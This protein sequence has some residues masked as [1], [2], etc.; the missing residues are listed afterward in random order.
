MQ[1]RGVDLSWSD[2]I[3]RLVDA[4]T[5]LWVRRTGDRLLASQAWLRSPIGPPSGE[6]GNWRQDYP[7]NRPPQNSAG[8]IS[9]FEAL[10]SPTFAVDAVD[11]A[12]QNFYTSTS[13]WTMRLNAEWSWWAIAP[14]WALRRIFSDRL[15]QL[16]IPITAHEDPI[17]S[18]VS[19]SDDPDSAQPV[20]IWTRRAAKQRVMFSGLYRTR[21]CDAENS[22]ALQVTFPLPEGNLNVF[23][24]PTALSGGG[25]LLESGRQICQYPA[26][27]FTVKQ[28]SDYY[29]RS[30][31]IDESFRLEAESDR[32]VRCTHTLRIWSIRVFTL[33]YTMERTAGSWTTAEDTCGEPPHTVDERR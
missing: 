10:I 33:Q 26:T 31:P 7:R 8:L 13:N 24:R 27:S 32:V 14:W 30:L 2:R 29:V 19:I 9:D 28:G 17:D 22:A 21:R 18:S 3:L 1:L 25:L 6:L 12:I 23:L 5:R 16:S 4:T 15:G 11:C 20:A